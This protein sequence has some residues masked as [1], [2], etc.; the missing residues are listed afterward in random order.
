MNVI[1]WHESPLSLHELPHNKVL[2]TLHSWDV[3]RVST[4]LEDTG[5]I[6]VGADSMLEAVGKMAFDNMLPLVVFCY[7]CISRSWGWSRGDF[8]AKIIC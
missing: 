8:I 4:L 3:P 7:R 2:E 5:I 1:L 6:E